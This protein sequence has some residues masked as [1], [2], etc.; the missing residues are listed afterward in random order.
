MVTMRYLLLLIAFATVL[1]SI[2]TGALAQ[3]SRL[4][5]RPLPRVDRSDMAGMPYEATVDTASW[6]TV[7]QPP[8]REIRVNDI[9]TIRVDITARA[10][11]E[12]DFQRRKNATFDSLLTNWVTLEGLTQ[13]KPSPQTEGDQRIGGTLNKQDR[14][15]SELETS[16]S[17]KF[18]IAATIASILPNGNV[19]LEAHRKVSN[20]EETWLQSLTGVCPKDAIG[21]GNVVLSKDIAQ[22]EIKKEELGSIKDSYKRGWFQRTWDLLKVF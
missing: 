13:I 20:N 7:P 18:E 22:L 21:P 11:Q 14:V 3:N 15:T 5:S 10:I 2:P 17:L 16:E 4:F 8:A 1:V 6:I 9:V 12:G 19:V